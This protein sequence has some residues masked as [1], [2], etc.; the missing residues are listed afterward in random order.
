MVGGIAFFFLFRKSSQPG[1]QGIQ[2]V[3]SYVPQTGTGSNEAVPPPSGTSPIPTPAPPPT[4]TPTPVGPTPAPPGTD[5][6]SQIEAV[7][8]QIYQLA[9]SQ[10][11]GFQQA[12]GF[13]LSGQPT[14]PQWQ[15]YFE[16][17]VA[18]SN[19]TQAQLQQTLT[20][21]TGWYQQMQ[22]ALQSPASPALVSSGASNPGALSQASTPS[23]SILQPIN[24]PPGYSLP[25]KGSQ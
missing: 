14:Y 20:D 8:A 19:P 1:Q 23:A 13:P 7:A 9:G 12:Q 18:Q 21:Y 4:P 11:P 17:Q 5:L 2:Y 6:V 3:L 22:R 15:Q 10:G 16:S 25:A 24:P